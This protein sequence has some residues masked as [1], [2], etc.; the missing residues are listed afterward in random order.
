[1]DTSS[2]HKLIAQL[3]NDLQKQVY[4]FANRW[5]A[6]EK[7]TFSKK[8]RVAGL[9]AGQMT[10]QDDFDDPLPDEFWLGEDK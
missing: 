10:V 9:H 4:D 3:P 8:T 1:M 6:K 7:Q 2:L 5:V